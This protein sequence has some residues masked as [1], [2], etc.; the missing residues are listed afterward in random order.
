ML[1]VQRVHREVN[2]DIRLIVCIDVSRDWL[3]GF[4]I[5]RNGTDGQ[6]RVQIR[7][8]N[9][10]EPIE[11]QLKELEEYA[12][13]V[14]LDGLCVVCEPTG[15]FERKVFETARRL[16][17]QTAYVNSEHVAK[18]SVIESGDTGKTDVSDA[19]VINLVVRLDR[20]QKVR[21]LEGE[22][23][24][25][26]QLGKDHDD[27]ERL[28]VQAR[29]RIIKTIRKL[30]CDYD[31]NTE[32]IFLSTGHAL[33]AEYT[34]NPFRIT[35]D[36]FETFRSRIKTHVQ[37]VR[38]STLEELWAQARCSARQFMPE[39]YQQVLEQRLQWLWEDWTRHEERKEELDREIIRVYEQLEERGEVPPPFEQIDRGQLGRFIGET[40]PL[41]NFD[42]WR[43]LLD[44]AGLKIRERESGEYEG[45]KKITKKG[46]SRLRKV[47]SRMAFALIG[48]KRLYADYYNRKC[49]SGM[50]G[51][52]ARVAVMRKVAK[53]IVGLHQSDQPYDPDRV[54]TCE[55]QYPA[56]S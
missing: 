2:P 40:G 21:L 46:R 5:H 35:G 56:A 47:L 55:S 25:L 32:F 11:Q 1:N 34:W 26:R 52:E 42:H 23:Q 44:F 24:L 31:K 41:D 13:Q 43:Q 20:T 48:Q 22:Y 14:G 12:D 18:L 28:V 53:L 50:S 30:F 15:N 17:H 3:D 10:L 7:C 54:F 9:R 49:Q 33:M 38:E 45:E 51:I 39:A 27:I 16:G 29:C 4:A 37:Q 36:G 6:A 19:R 8:K